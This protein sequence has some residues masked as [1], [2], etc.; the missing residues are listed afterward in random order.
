MRKYKVGDVVMIHHISDEALEEATHCCRANSCL[1]WAND[2]LRKNL[3]NGVRVEIL[4]AL[5]DPLDACPYSVEFLEVFD[6]E[7]FI[8][9]IDGYILKVNELNIRP[10]VN[11]KQ[12][13]LEVEL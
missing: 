6:A 10:I 4:K 1:P 5:D 9:Q 12:L 7:N 3:P 8:F 11:K 13:V 2:I